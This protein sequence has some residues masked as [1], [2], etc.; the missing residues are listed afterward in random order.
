L[1]THPSIPP[2]PT[3]GKVYNL[4][5]QQCI[6]ISYCQSPLHST[7]LYQTVATIKRT[8]TKKKSLCKYQNKKFV[9]INLIPTPK[10]MFNQIEKKSGKFDS[11]FF[12]KFYCHHPQSGWCKYMFSFDKNL[13]FN[14]T[15]SID[16][17]KY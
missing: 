13:I 9:Y 1:L 7:I 17:M 4:S 3:L 10:I 6:I 8:L 2:P 14:L 11:I 16:E 5:V 12:F 15:L